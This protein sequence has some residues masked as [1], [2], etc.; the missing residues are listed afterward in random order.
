MRL[1]PIAYCRRCG[2]KY[3][4]VFGPCEHCSEAAK[5]RRKQAALGRRV[6]IAGRVQEGV[7]RRG[8]VRAWRASKI[9]KTGEET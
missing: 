8:T 1:A 7:T 6:E 2:V 4:F 3:R 5:E 9:E